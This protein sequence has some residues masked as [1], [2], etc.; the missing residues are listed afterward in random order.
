ME[1]LLDTPEPLAPRPPWDTSSC[2]S[3]EQEA[4]MRNQF[5][6]FLPKE[7]TGLAK[8]SSVFQDKINKQVSSGMTCISSLGE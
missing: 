4:G 6:S 8:L 7:N 2:Q 1:L 3:K 5:P